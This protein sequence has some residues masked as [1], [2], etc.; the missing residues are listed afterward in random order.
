MRD[1][2]AAGNSPMDGIATATGTLIEAYDG[3]VSDLDGVVYRGH[4]AVPHAVQSLLSALSAGVRIV[5]ATNNASR[6]PAEVSGHLGDL[7]LPGTGARVVTSAQ[8]AARLVAKRCPAGCR[9]LAVGGPGVALAL[10]DAGFLAV[11]PQQSRSG[12]PVVAVVQGYGA[13]VG[14]ADLAEIAYAVHAGAFWVATNVDITLPTDRGLAP[15]NGALVAAVRSAVGVDPVTVGK[16]NPPLYEL[17][18]SVLGTDIGRTLAIGDRLDTDIAGATAVGMDS[19]FVFGGV[20]GWADLAGAEPAARPRYVAT[21]LRSLHRVY[22]ETAQDGADASRWMC[23]EAWARVSAA[24]ELVVAQG[25]AVNERVR[26]A[27][28]AVWDARDRRSS[29]IDP[30]GGDGA[31]LSRELDLAV[32]LER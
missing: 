6:T 5:Y 30:L 21:D 28:R 27:L 4:R 19:L 26:A 17:S 32:G 31:A 23:G 11:S 10:E 25:G 29:T 22:A 7:G 13:N 18:A 12:E 9:V 2:G 20:H 16:P 3:I 14:W 1:I 24:G 15:G 8:A